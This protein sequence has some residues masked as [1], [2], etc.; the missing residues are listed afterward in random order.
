M[1]VVCL[2]I[3]EGATVTKKKKGCPHE[4]SPKQN[5]RNKFSCNGATQQQARNSAALSRPLPIQTLMRRARREAADMSNLR[6]T[7]L[8]LAALAELLANAVDWVIQTD[9]QRRPDS[10]ILCGT[11]VY[12]RMTTAG[13][14]VVAAAL[15]GP[16]L[17]I[18]A[19]FRG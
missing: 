14:V 16:A 3:Q 15:A 9:G 8:E 4:S 5:I 7:A 2:L 13:E 1:L 12:I 10:V 6:P 17:V 19:P 18:S 11:R